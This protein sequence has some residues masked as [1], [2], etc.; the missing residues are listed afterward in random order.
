MHW[1]Y[2][3]LVL[4]H[5][6]VLYLSVHGCCLSLQDT[7]Y[8]CCKDGQT[9]AGGRNYEQCPMFYSCDHMA[10][11]C[12]PDGV[13]SAMGPH[14]EGCPLTTTP[15][16]SCERSSFGCCPDGVSLAS[17][18]WWNPGSSSKFIYRQVS[19]IRC[20][21]SQHLK[22]SRTVLQL[23]LPNPLKLDVKSRMKM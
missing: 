17:G 10:Y 22:D 9:P 18:Q 8:G 16:P 2:C 4:S 20:T 23:S 15:V 19:N 7:L 13:S 3:S 11:G 6:N 5:Q 12:C 14:F 21:K 1:S